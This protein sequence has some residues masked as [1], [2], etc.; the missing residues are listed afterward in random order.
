MCPE[1]PKTTYYWSFTENAWWP[2]S[3]LFPPHCI[4]SVERYIVPHGKIIDCKEVCRRSSVCPICFIALP[5]GW[6]DYRSSSDAWS[7]PSAPGSPG[8]PALLW[9]WKRLDPSKLS[10]W[11]MREGRGL[12]A[13][14]VPWTQAF[15]L[16]LTGSWGASPVQRI[17]VL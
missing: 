9:G 1:R 6:E 7:L 11:R 14:S 17:P 10:H 8:F 13:I 2:A 16:F 3:L 5:N 15:K 4:L 12:A